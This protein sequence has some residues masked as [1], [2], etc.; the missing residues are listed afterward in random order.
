ML[1]RGSFICSFLVITLVSKSKMDSQQSSIRQ[2]DVDCIKGH[3]AIIGRSRKCPQRHSKN[4]FVSSSICIGHCTKN[5]QYIFSYSE[6]K[7]NKENDYSY[8][9]LLE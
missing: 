1:E 7:L 2:V 9:L 4:L 5:I 6:L 8:L 3:Y